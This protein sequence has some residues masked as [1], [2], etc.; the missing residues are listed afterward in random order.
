MLK[1]KEADEAQQTSQSKEEQPQKHFRDYPAGESSDKL[2]E[3]ILKLKLKEC[4]LK[5]KQAVEGLQEEQTQYQSLKNLKDLIDKDKDL[6]IEAW[7]RL[8]GQAKTRQNIISKIKKDI[9]EASA[10]Q[11]ARELAPEVAQALEELEPKASARNSRD[12]LLT[13]L[14]KL[15]PFTNKDA[16]KSAVEKALKNDQ[17][18]RLVVIWE[19]EFDRESK[20]YALNMGALFSFFKSAQRLESLAKL[21]VVFND[22]GASDLPQEQRDSRD[23]LNIYHR[24]MERWMKK[25]NLKA[26]FIRLSEL[27]EKSFGSVTGDKEIAQVLST[28]ASQAEVLL[29]RT[30]E[31]GKDLFSN[32]PGVFLQFDETK[33]HK[34]KKMHEEQLMNWIKADLKKRNKEPGQVEAIINELYDLFSEDKCAFVHAWNTLLQDSRTRRDI[35][36]LLRY[37]APQLTQ[38]INEIKKEEPMAG[39]ELIMEVLTRRSVRKHQPLNEMDVKKAIARALESGEPV[40]LVVFWGGYREA[41]PMAGELDNMA[42]KELA[43]TLRAVEEL[44]HPTLI[45][46]D[47]LHGRRGPRARLTIWFTLHFA[48]EVNGKDAGACSSYK[49]SLESEVK[50]LSPDGT[51]SLTTDASAYSGL[52]KGMLAEA[53]KRAEA[54]LRERQDVSD[55][56]CKNA[57]LYSE[58]VHKG[59]MNPEQA[60]YKFL[61]YRIFEAGRLAEL[62]PGRIFISFGDKR[63]EETFS[64]LPT[65]FF[66]PP[67]IK[68]EESGRPPWLAAKQHA[69]GRP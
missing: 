23:S 57:Q 5:L 14:E 6:F 20:R 22:L 9:A 33:M 65:L 3:C 19:P 7:G 34:G 15:G 2:K 49:D 67:R 4:I 55:E 48:I 37:E 53:A 29:I 16:V 68:G 52:D 44:K 43:E 62:W 66:H 45:H 21:S 27:R 38:L 28:L 51:I 58:H 8:Y 10:D 69:Q 56:L 63:V 64:P 18:P 25:L 1:V 41:G 17:T 39:A 26:D 50:K 36:D 42:L 61:T 12:A 24:V 35:E 30:D 11:R 59:T 40:E 54:I 13:D 60:A 47:E 31:E 46:L 32:M